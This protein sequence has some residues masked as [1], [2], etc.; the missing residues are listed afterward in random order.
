[1]NMYN[2][3]GFTIVELVVVMWIIAILS[4]IWFLSYQWYA[5][6]SRDTKRRADISNI[7]TQLELNK[8][9]WEDIFSFTLNEESTIESIIYIS[10]I[11]SKL[12]LWST[13]EAWDADYVYLDIVWSSFL[14]P[15]TED[16]YKIWVTSHQNRYEIAASL[17]NDGNY[18]SYVDGTWLPRTIIE[19]QA[20]IEKIEWNVIH[21]SWITKSNL[22]LFS[23]DIV[24]IWE[25]KT[26]QYVIDK[27]FHSKILLETPVVWTWS[28]IELYFDESEHIIKSWSWDFPISTNS[29]SEFTPYNL[30][31]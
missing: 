24:T 25:D 10:G 14:D 6:D 30:D 12:N 29:G 7:T 20:D 22:L 3:K 11:E 21:L 27:V 5:W 8:S 31:I 23:N 1:M 4:T 15:K 2:I 16:I 28:T 9:R 17:E 13:Y 18:I 19:T 26:Q